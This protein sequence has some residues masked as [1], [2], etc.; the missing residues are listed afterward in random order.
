MENSRLFS[1]N[2]S[3]NSVKVIE[4]NPI[5]ANRPNTVRFNTGQKLK[6]S[7]ILAL[8]LLRAHFSK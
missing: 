2:A 6:L 3:Q 1:S 4:S 8:H 5:P 7:Q